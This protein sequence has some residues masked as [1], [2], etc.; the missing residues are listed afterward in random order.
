MASLVLYLSPPSDGLP[1]PLFLELFLAQTSTSSSSL[2]PFLTFHSPPSSS[3]LLSCLPFFIFICFLYS[4]SSSPRTCRVF[5]VFLHTHAQYFLL[6]LLPSHLTY[7]II[8]LHHHLP[9]SSS[10][11]SFVIIVFLLL[12]LQIP[13]SSTLVSHPSFAS[14]AHHHIA[15]DDIKVIVMLFQGHRARDEQNLAHI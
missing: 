9:P 15:N 3:L 2:L 10:P 7:I 11:S 1:P 8:F 6:F 4:P 13:S 12:H 5:F 14:L